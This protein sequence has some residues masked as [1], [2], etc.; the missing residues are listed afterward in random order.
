MQWG[1]GGN[2]GGTSELIYSPKSQSLPTN[3]QYN[4]YGNEIWYTL[5]ISFST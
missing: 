5:K 2:Q 1:G 3:P 4:S